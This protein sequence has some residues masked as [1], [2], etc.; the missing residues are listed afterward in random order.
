MKKLNK[1]IKGET[2]QDINDNDYTPCSISQTGFQPRTR[3]WKRLKSIRF[4]LSPAA[5]SDAGLAPG[6]MVCPPK[7]HCLVGMGESLASTG[8]TEG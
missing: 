5:V 3:I 7:S 6:F 8:A 1:V 2:L 4:P